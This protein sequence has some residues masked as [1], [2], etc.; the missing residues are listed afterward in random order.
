MD[1]HRLHRAVPYSLTEHRFLPADIHMRSSSENFLVSS[2]H[3]RLRQGKQDSLVVSDDE[4][5]DAMMRNRSTD[6]KYGGVSG[7]VRPS[8]IQR[9]EGTTSHHPKP[10]HRRHRSECF[11]G[12]SQKGLADS[13]EGQTQILDEI[14]LPGP[15]AALCGRVRFAPP[16]VPCSPSREIFPAENLIDSTPPARQRRPYKLYE[17]PR[18]T[19]SG[20]HD[21][22]VG[23]T[24]RESTDLLT[25]KTTTTRRQEKEALRQEHEESWKSRA[26]PAHEFYHHN[27]GVLS[28]TDS[29]GS[30]FLQPHK[31]TKSLYFTQNQVYHKN[32]QIPLTPL[33]AQSNTMN[34]SVSQ[35][36]HL[37]NHQSTMT[38][39]SPPSDRSISDDAALNEQP[40]LLS[41]RPR[42]RSIAIQRSRINYYGRNGYGDQPSIS[43]SNE[44]SNEHMYDYA[45]WRM[46]H[47]IVDHRKSQQRLRQDDEQRSSNKNTNTDDRQ[48]MTQEDEALK[49]NNHHSMLMMAFPVDHSSSGSSSCSDDEIFDMEL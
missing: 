20:S 15:S 35:C 4:E 29:P 44:E 40:P 14:L 22:N 1:P 30:L 41:M 45:T 26:P 37:Q 28:M 46:Y 47:R 25:V 8:C 5:D 9:V 17:K 36:H 13:D 19:T 34:P 33:H 16:P 39:D 11:E 42:T 32:S 12:K 21:S 10:H 3:H 49:S 43:S 48:G 27:E 24:I 23:S 38:M 31:K 2:H 7:D 18:T 6:V